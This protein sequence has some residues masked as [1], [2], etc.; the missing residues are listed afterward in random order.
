MA[1][2]LKRSLETKTR[3]RPIVIVSGLPRSGT[4]MMMQMLEAGGMPVM[5]DHARKADDDN[6]RGYYEFERVKKMKDD[7]SW[8]D[9]CHGKAVKIVSSLLYHLPGDNR[10]KLI[11]MRREMEEILASQKVMLQRAGQEEGRLGGRAMAEK[12]EEHLIKI[13]GWLKRQR[14][15][16]TLFLS[17]N[18]V[19]RDP[20]EGARRLIGFIGLKSDTAKIAG[21]I[22]LLLYRKRKPGRQTE[23][24]K[25]TY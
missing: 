11:F 16:K 24:C 3:N 21:S 13:E 18:D 19:L 15:I 12:L 22:D 10:Y 4:S 20:H 14:N 5:T 25:A 2:S 23:Q 7:T 17:Y 8:L 6:P 1:F 9:N